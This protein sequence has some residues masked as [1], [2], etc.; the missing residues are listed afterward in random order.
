M[1]RD[2]A[3]GSRLIVACTIL[4]VV[5]S[6]VASGTVLRSIFTLPLVLFLP[7]HALLRLAVSSNME[8]FEYATLA[9][10]LSMAIAVLGGLI[11]HMFGAMTP[12]GW[13]LLLGGITIGAAAWDLHSNIARPIRLNLSD[14]ASLSRKQAAVIACSLVTVFAAFAIARGGASTHREFFHTDLWLVPKAGNA[15][16]LGIKNVE[17]HQATYDIELTFDGESADVWRSI[18]LHPGQSWTKEIRVPVRAGAAPRVEA[19]L[20][21]GDDRS[22]V[23]RKVWIAASE[24][25]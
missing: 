18:G 25:K 13:A 12:M 5:V 7:G 14:L 20:F 22:T 24:T 16:T 3:R 2:S 9:V 17:G 8:R 1:M 10:G 21:R 23:Y 19:W 11:L 6:L 4:A 15:M